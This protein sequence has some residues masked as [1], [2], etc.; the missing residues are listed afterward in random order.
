VLLDA[1]TH[2]RPHKPAWTT[3]RSAEWIQSMRDSKFDARV[4]DALLDALMVED[5]ATLPRPSFGPE[6]PLD[7]PLPQLDPFRIAASRSGRGLTV[8][9][10]RPGRATAS[11]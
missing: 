3:E 5:L 4:V 11:P 9:R 6:L 8:P 10:A 7:L 2:A 1:L